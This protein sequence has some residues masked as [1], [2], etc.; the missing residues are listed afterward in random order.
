MRGEAGGEQAE[1]RGTEDR[2]DR[3]LNAEK[4]RRQ[5]AVTPGLLSLPSSLN[6][7]SGDARDAA[8]RGREALEVRGGARNGRQSDGERRRGTEC[9]LRRRASDAVNQTFVC[10][11]DFPAGLWQERG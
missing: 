8:G 1:D 4:G 5:R 11:A 3:E 10:D 7:A 2:A 9:G 6:R